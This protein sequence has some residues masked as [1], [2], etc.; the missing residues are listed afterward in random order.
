M[1]PVRLWAAVEFT[2]Q[3][4][5]TD[6]LLGHAAQAG[7]H[8]TRIVPLPGGFRARC[9]AWHYRPLAALARQGHVRLRVEKRLGLFFRLR[10]LLRRTG[11]WA[12]LALFIPLLLWSQQ[13]VWAVDT[14][15]LTRGQAARAFAVLRQADLAPGAAATEAKRNAGEYAL[16]ESGEFSWASLNFAKG[17]L[18]VRAAAAVPKPAIAAG[19]LHGLRARCAGVVIKTNLTSGTMLVVPGQAVEAGQGLIGTAR[20][21][22]DGTLIFAPA[23]GTV[24]AQFE[25]SDTRT[26]PL[27]ETVQQY[28][29]ACTRAY[30]VT[31]FGHTFSLP[32]A[33]APEHAAV[34]LRHFQPEVPLLGLAL[35]CSVEET[36]RYVQQPETLRRTEAQAAAL[37][38]LQSLQALYAAWPD[39]E[40]IA[41]KEDCTVNGN[42]LD[43][44]VTYTV[45]A[46]ICG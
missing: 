12:G 16:L 21:E 46:D 25:W 19:T 33:P 45:A 10:P 38:R 14:S 22:R 44:T 27:E 20:Q 32:A 7:L 13:F 5:S 34:I 2:A 37:A 30:R 3:S 15:T 1:E 26:V 29:G 28:T 11:L 40:H 42:V 6:A 39:A 18:E 41:R 36:C 24:I 35:P 43:Y 31:A 8:L 4:G 17:R 23:A 9:A